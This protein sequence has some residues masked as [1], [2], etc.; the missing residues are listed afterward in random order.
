MGRRTL[1]HLEELMSMRPIFRG[2]WSY[3]RSTIILIWKLIGISGAWHLT[4][5]CH[6]EKGLR[7]LV[8][9]SEK[10]LRVT[11]FELVSETWKGLR[12]TTSIF[13]HLIPG[14]SGLFLHQLWNFRKRITLNLSES[15]E[16]PEK[17][18]ERLMYI[19]AQVSG[20]WLAQYEHLMLIYVYRYT[21]ICICIFIYI[22]IHIQTYTYIYIQIQI[23][24]CTQICLYIYILHVSLSF[25][26]LSPE[27]NGM[28]LMPYIYTYVY[29]HVCIYI[30]IYTYIYIY[31]YIYI[32]IYIYIYT[33]IHMQ[34]YIYTH[35]HIYK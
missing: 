35:T 23:Y 28:S 12:V 19:D 31:V 15:L 8:S 16:H 27:N 33:C 29:T 5:T 32:Y 20:L 26:S 6:S 1:P 14:P 11:I 2:G 13:W 21:Y 24:I 4:W 34:I 22:Y 30:Y 10:G 18:N 3:F 17:C 7:E 9:V 25:L